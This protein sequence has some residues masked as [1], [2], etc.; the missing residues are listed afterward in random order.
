MKTRLL[1][2]LG[3]AVVGIPIIIFSKFIVFPIALA[4]LSTLAS[5]EM[6]RT[7]GVHKKLWLSLPAYI[8]AAA[9][10]ILAYFD[11]AR[12]EGRLKFLLILAGVL[13]VYLIYLFFVAVFMRG[14]IKYST[15]SEI[16][17]ASLYVISSF[18]AIC[19]T[20]YMTGG[21]WFLVMLLIA[22]WGSDSFAYFTG[23]LFGKHK[24]I[25]E[26]SPKKTVEGSVGGIICAALLMTLYGFLVGSFTSYT[27][28][29]LVLLLAGLVL[30]A[31]SQVGDLIASLIKRENG[32]KDYGR[33]FPGHGGVMDRFDSVLSIATA[34][35][36]ICII[37]PPFT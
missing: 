13:F 32:I 21:V 31:A 37:A 36:I 24:L 23:M 6:M 26:I 8:I 19:V 3:M 34:L 17:T 2:A 1:T 33:V 30:S 7:F 29:Y 4:L 11:F 20:R 14:E 12:G 27:P 25:P 10:P 15:V 9:M 16:F 35:M 18:T 5:F 22:A 28:N